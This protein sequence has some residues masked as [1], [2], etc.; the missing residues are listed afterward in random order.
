MKYLILLLVICF[1][2]ISCGQDVIQTSSIESSEPSSVM[3]VSSEVS[4]EVSLETSSEIIV[5][6][7]LSKIANTISKKLKMRDL[8]LADEM[9][10]AGMLKIDSSTYDGFYGKVSYVLDHFDTV[11]VFYC[12]T[13]QME[14][15]LKSVLS[16]A[17]EDYSALHTEKAKVDIDNSIIFSQN[18]Y[19]FWVVANDTSDFEEIVIPLL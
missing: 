12:H 3:E 4:S 13:E 6:N 18:G 11:L 14:E 19:V 8:V 17:K 2:F 1:T 10:V 7:D 5:F 15:N 9:V 16:K